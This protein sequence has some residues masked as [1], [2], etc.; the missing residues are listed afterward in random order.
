MIEVKVLASSSKGNCYRVTDGSSS[1]LLECGIPW[2]E[3]Q[4]GLN[5]KT[6]ELVGC[7]MSHSHKDHCKAAADVVKAGIDCYMS[8][9]TA[10][11]L[12]VSGHRIKLIEP[13]RQFL[14]G[15]SWAILPFDTQ[16][17]CEGSLGFLLANKSGDKLLFITDSYYCKYKF[18]GIT[19]LMIECNHSYDI[20]DRNAAS[21]ALP[22]AMKDR[23]IQS[24]FSLENV[25]EFLKANDLSKM[26]EIWL[27]HL[28]D[29]NSDAVRFRRE[30]KELTGKPVYV[31][32]GQ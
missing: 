15:C 12:G 17:D 19:H 22:L 1:I 23:L 29:G 9:P 13:L 2:K 16:H 26:Q 6:S 18:N 31:A 21:G 10:E 30:I 24:H 5:F 25:K 7:L 8:K 32:G 27:I 4:R 3:I 20:L 11:V 14:I 28:S